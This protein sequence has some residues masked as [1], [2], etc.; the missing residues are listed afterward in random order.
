MKRSKMLLSF[1][2]RLICFLLILAWVLGA[3]VYVLLPKYDYG[4]CPMTAFYTQEEN[5]VD[6]LVM[7][8]SCA[9]S[10]VNTNVLFEEFG[11]AAYNLCSA[12][13]PYWVTYHYL[14]EA[15]K[16]Q[17]P[18]VILLDA[19]PSIY[20]DEY[21]KRGRTILATY[22]IRDIRTRLEAVM[23]CVGPEKFLDFALVFNELHSYYKDVKAENFIYPPTNGGR[24]PDWK[25][26]IEMDMVQFHEEPAVVW[27]KTRKELHPRQE[28][29]FTKIL[30]LANAYGIP[31]M[32]VGFPSPDYVNEHMYYNSLWHAAKAHGVS[33]VNYNN[34]DLRLKL[35]YATD[36]ADWQHLNINGSVIFTRRLAKDLQA[37]F[38]LPDRRGQE[39]YASW[40]RCADAWYAKYP[41]YV[42]ERE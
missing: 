38:D 33:G 37:A 34:P 23:A 10:G 14:K 3:V 31:V 16:T 40:Q 8:T 36:F 29:Y 5:S 6:V 26:Y 7:G 13:Q 19:K 1:W 21:S 2:M 11:I 24:G 18:K 28:E 17:R 25:G 20:Q 41:D 39:E 30:E 4:I 22:G 27:T 32:L 35:H 12:E 42:P 9:Y 15:L